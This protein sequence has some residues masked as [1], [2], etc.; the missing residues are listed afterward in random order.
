MNK[1]TS[2]ILLIVPL[3]ITFAI[4]GYV[5][6]YTSEYLS[7]SDLQRYTEPAK[8]TVLGNVSKGSVRFVN[9]NIEFLLTDGE[10]YVKVVY[11][12]FVQLDNSTNYAQVTVIGV[13]Y[14]SKNVIEADEI[15]FKCPSKEQMEVRNQS[16]AG[17]QS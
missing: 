14:P 6:L 15:L 11:P 8:V 1:K 3:S 7:V 17:V 10:S 2:L 12:S 9:G 13:F 4:L 5:S 16:S